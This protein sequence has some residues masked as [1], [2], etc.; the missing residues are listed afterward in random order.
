MCKR[1]SLLIVGLFLFPFLSWAQEGMHVISAPLQNARLK[2]EY[3]FAKYDV[4]THK[5]NSSTIVVTTQGD[6]DKSYAM[7]GCNRYDADGRCIDLYDFHCEHE[8]LYYA[9]PKD[10]VIFDGDTRL[11]YI[12][13]GLYLTIARHDRNPFFPLFRQWNFYN[14]TYMQF[15]DNASTLDFLLFIKEKE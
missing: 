5:D 12:G 7:G 6:C 13:D 10:K 1:V 2:P 4:E 15:G 14:I 8:K 9:L 11:K 3:S